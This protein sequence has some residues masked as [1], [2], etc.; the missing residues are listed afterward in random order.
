MGSRLPLKTYTLRCTVSSLIRTSKTKQR[1]NIYLMPLRQVRAP[2]NTYT[3]CTL[4]CQCVTLLSSA[5]CKEE[6]RLGSQVDQFQDGQFWRTCDCFR[7]SRRDLL[8]WIICSHILVEEKVS[9]AVKLSW[10]YRK[11]SQIV[12]VYGSACT[13]SSRLS[14]S[15][16]S[17]TL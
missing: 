5:L 13:K 3:S 14:V 10:A 16:L 4:G 7:C 2:P 12:T 8:L 9:I 17:S 6:G 1:G 15:S 11:V